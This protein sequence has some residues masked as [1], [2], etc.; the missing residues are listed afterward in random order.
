MAPARKL[1]R[2]SL[3]D[4]S[5]L[6]SFLEDG[7]GPKRGMDTAAKHC[8]AILHAAVRD[9][10]AG[11][12]AVDLSKSRVPGIPQFAR[13]QI[14]RKFA[15]VTTTIADCQTSKDGSTTKMVVETQDGHRVESVV[16]RHDKGG[17]VTLC[18]S[19]QVGCKMGCTFCA[20]GTL[21][22]LGNL[23][24]GEILEQLVHANRLFNGNGNADDS[25]DDPADDTQTDNR[26]R[27]DKDKR[28]VSGTGRGVRNLVFMG[29]GEPL[30]NYDSV[31]DAIGPMTDPTAFG[32][33]PSKVTVST[34]GVV[35][36]MRRLIVDAP[37]VCLALSLHAPNQA[38][39]ERIVPTATAY[40]L[41]D[42]LAALDHYLAAG[43]P[44]TSAMIEYC[45]LGG[46][47]D[48]V[49][50][51]RELGHLMRDRDVIVNLIPY[52]PTDVPMGHEPPTPE[53][54]R[55]MYS[56]LT[57]REFKVF[58]TVRH[59][60]GQDI[61]GACGQLALKKGPSRGSVVGGGGG[62]GGGTGD[63]EDLGGVVSKAKDGSGLRRRGASYKKEGVMDD[64][65]RLVENKE[66]KNGPAKKEANEHRG[67]SA[68]G[69]LDAGA[70]SDE[71]N[72]NAGVERR[73]R[74]TWEDVS[75]VFLLVVAFGSFTVMVASLGHQLWIARAGD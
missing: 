73:P 57:G 41:P 53:A 58:T 8:R 46:V 23:T 48:S 16:M 61:S 69:R 35:P 27:D 15:L 47:N 62:S 34:V 67:T 38:L 4:R 25:R 74:W 63:I 33:A 66:E 5:A 64:E 31:V 65:G 17:R 55:A 71:T 14:P 32:L 43:G 11:L 40:K 54:V 26:D 36:K 18:V 24:S 20:T 60:M 70:V 37:G 39:R 7:L 12:D 42:I 51:A 6:M 13:D 9:A 44:K 68:G 22:E 72:E 28:R 30:N 49:E 29:M 19:S 45:V 21:G 59:E 56:V 50:C 1:T 10:E 2:T 3:F 75:L 52:N